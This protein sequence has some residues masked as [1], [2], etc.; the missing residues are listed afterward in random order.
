MANL[1]IK[2]PGDLTVDEAN[3]I[4][5]KLRN[6]LI[7]GVESL[8]YVAIQIKSHDFETSYFRPGI[9]GAIS[10]RRKGRHMSKESVASGKGP[11][12]KCVCSKCGYE[13]PHERGVPCSSLKCPKCK[14]ALE[15]VD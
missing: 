2:L 15:R 7:E 4:S 3:K 14:I 5:E 12:G 11:D 10:W 1:E 6:K 8:N 9:G 13:A